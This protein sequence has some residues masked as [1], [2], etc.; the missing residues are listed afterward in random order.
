MKALGIQ[1]CLILLILCSVSGYS[2]VREVKNRAAKNRSGISTSKSSSG[3]DADILVGVGA[4][5]IGEF[6]FIF[7]WIGRQQRDVLSR[8]E[9]EP[10]L[11]SLDMYTAGAYF[12][13]YNNIALN[14]SARLHWGVFSTDL[15]W[16]RMQDLSGMYETLDWQVLQINLV[17]HRNFRLYG[18]MGFSYE[19]FTDSYFP[20][21]GFGA[22]FHISDR[23]INPMFMYRISK[24]H[25]TGATPREEI[26]GE[27]LTRIARFARTELL[28]DLG[29]VY[30]KY[31]GEPDFYFLKTGMV[32]RISRRN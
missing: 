8:R 16:F 2:Q 9:E 25:F 10:W 19:Y 3:S 4:D 15:R 14:P 32:L 18:G 29:L 22:D 26:S 30:Q 21:Y 28:L 6:F 23:K 1:T 20:E 7:E 24:D 13:E 31:Y 27:I 12:I 5:F 11:V 17:N